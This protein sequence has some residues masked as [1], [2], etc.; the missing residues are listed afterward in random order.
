M[1][2]IES[3][4]HELAVQA[5]ERAQGDLYQ[6]QETCGFQSANVPFG[7]SFQAQTCSS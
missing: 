6:L 4:N 3:L 1:G 5:L 2:G 7:L